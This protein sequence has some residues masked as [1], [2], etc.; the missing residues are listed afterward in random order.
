M[1]HATR[2]RAAQDPA[3]GAGLLSAALERLGELG[4]RHTR[5]RVALL[6]ALIAEHGPFSVDELLKLPSLK[7]LDRVTVYRCMSAFEDAGLVSRCEF[8]DGSS[9]YEFAS[10]GHHHHHVVCKRCRRT[11]SLP[12]SM[13]TC[14][15][16]ALLSQ[17]SALGYAEI[18]HTLEF[19]GIC[20]ECRTQPARSGKGKSFERK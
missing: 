6:E 3:R 4:L 2:K 17:V 5:P 18:S 8:G 12:E 1:S 13:D 15:P 10:G 11:E 20:R 7:G 16:K 14:I 19:F 9:R